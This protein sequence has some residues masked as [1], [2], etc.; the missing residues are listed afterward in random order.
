[1]GI[2]INHVW[3]W[4]L[5]VVLIRYFFSGGELLAWFSHHIA[6]QSKD[7]DLINSFC[8]Q[9]LKVGQ[10]E[11]I[12]YN[13]ILNNNLNNTKTTPAAK[14]QE[15]KVSESCHSDGNTCCVGLKGIPLLCTLEGVNWSFGIGKI[16]EKFLV[17]LEL[18]SVFG[19]LL[20]LYVIVGLLG[21][22]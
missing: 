5:T 1:M 9:L 11:Q 16:Q 13:D 2:V 7:L 4:C 12:S 20:M 3:V 8:T 22:F 19:M 10:L 14:L 18:L 17:F 21:I 15:F 6:Q